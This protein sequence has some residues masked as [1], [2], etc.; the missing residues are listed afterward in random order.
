MTFTKSGRSGTSGAQHPVP[1]AS[2]TKVM[3]AHVILKGHPLKQGSP[4]PLITVDQRAEDESFSSVES[5]V[6]VEEGREYSQR[7]LLEMLLL[8]SGNNIARLLARWDAGSED[9]FTGKMN[10][11]AA[12]LGMKRTTYT[13]ASGIEPTTTSTSGDQVRLA[14]EVMRDPAFRSIVATAEVTVGGGVGTLTHTNKLLGTS[15][16]IGVKTGSSTPAGGALMWAARTTRSAATDTDDD[17]I[18][19]VVLHQ[20]PDTP[21]AQ[22]LQAAYDATERLVGAA[23]RVDRHR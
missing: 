7:Q 13:G 8:S 6:P 3:T 23:Q 2:V 18:L 9:A 14:R 11:V 12:D 21:P 4:G 1:I 5:T 10:A 17:L 20:N 22:G 19:G 15:G 16:I